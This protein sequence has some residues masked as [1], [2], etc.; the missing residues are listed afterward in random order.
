MNDRTGGDARLGEDIRLLGRILG[1]TIRVY[2]GDAAFDLIEDIR[3]LS[4]AGRRLED[5]ASR[6]RLSRT[7]D[8]LST[9]QAVAVVRAFSYFSLLANI[10]E[11]RHHIRRHREYRREGKP[12]LPSTLRG[13]FLEAR[14]RGTGREEAARRL[15]AVR[16][17][18]VLTAHPTEVRRKSNL[19]CQ[20]AIAEGLGRL[21]SRDA[22]PDEREAIVVELRRLIATLWQTRMLRTVKLGVRDEIENALAYFDYTFIDAV[23]ALVADVEDAVAALPG[24]GERPELPALLA[25][26]SWV[27]GDRDGN[28]AVTAAVTLDAMEIQAD[29]VLRG[30]ETAL[31]RIGRSLH[32][33]LG[34]D[35]ARSRAGRPPGRRASRPARPAR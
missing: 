33:R 13:L 29:H 30:L 5:V 10:A 18:P 35:P 19:D 14:E 23:P 20:L 34:D 7:L 3:R 11:D 22:L 26:G 32:G 21:D 27:G 9:A 6:E 4:V 8:G 12:P 2:E 24:T 25:V 28:P 16:V 15:S 31:I 17:H 1:D